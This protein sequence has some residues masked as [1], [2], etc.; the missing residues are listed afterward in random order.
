M[1]GKVHNTLWFGMLMNAHYPDAPVIWLSIC[2]DAQNRAYMIGSDS[3]IRELNVI[4]NINETL[5]VWK[6]R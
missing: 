1:D 4:P 3:E 5:V 6:R 2:V